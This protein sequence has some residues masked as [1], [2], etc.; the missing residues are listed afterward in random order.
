M[1]FC[2]KLGWSAESGGVIYGGCQLEENPELLPSLLLLLNDNATPEERCELVTLNEIPM[3]KIALPAAPDF[4]QDV[5]V[6]KL[7]HLYLANSNSCLWFAVGG[8]NAHEIIRASISRCNDAAGRIT[9]PIA[10]FELNLQRW[11]EYPQDDPTGLTALHQYALTLPT[12]YQDVAPVLG[13]ILPEISEESEALFRRALALGGSQE[14]RMVFDADESGAVARG[15]VGSAIARGFAALI[16]ETAAEV[17]AEAASPA[18]EIP[19]KVE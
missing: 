13:D 16:L 17:Q 8:E 5:D 18:D 6:V 12:A 4:D 7:S 10:V 14:I 1:E 3:L 9:T 19:A 15:T 11:A 2:A